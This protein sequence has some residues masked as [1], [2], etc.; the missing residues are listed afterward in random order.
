MELKFSQKFYSDFKTNRDVVFIYSETLDLLIVNVYNDARLTADQST[1]LCLTNF[2][3]KRLQLNRCLIIGDFNAHHT[4]WEPSR[5]S[6]K[7]GTELISLIDTLNLTVITP[8]NLPTHAY[9]CTGNSARTSTID[10][11]LCNVPNLI[12]NIA[13]YDPDIYTG[14]D[15]RPVS[16]DLC[17]MTTRRLVFTNNNHLNYK[18]ADWELVNR[19][20]ETAINPLMLQLPCCHPHNIETVTLCLTNAITKTCRDHIPCINP[21]RKRRHAIW[22]NENCRL[23]KKQKNAMDR[24]IDKLLDMTLISSRKSQLLAQRKRGFRQYARHLCVEKRA[25]LDTLVQ[26]SSRNDDWTIHEKIICFESKKDLPMLHT[27]QGTPAVNWEENFEVMRAKFFQGS[28]TT[29]TIDQTPPTSFSPFPPILASECSAAVAKM[30]NRTTG[31]DDK[32]N[33]LL[34]KKVWHTVEPIFIKLGNE[35][36]RHS[37]HPVSWKHA[38]TK[39]IP[40]TGRSDYLIA[41]SYRPIALLSILT[42]IFESIMSR[43]LSHIAEDRNLLPQ[44]QHGFRKNH[45]TTDGLTK[46][47]DYIHSGWKVKKVTSAL[48]LDLAG[49]YDNVC[50]T[51]LTLKLREMNFPCYVISWLNHFLTNRSTCIRNEEHFSDTWYLKKGLPQGS[52]I[53]SILFIL[54]TADLIFDLNA[55]IPTS[56]FADDI[57]LYVANASTDANVS[58]LKTAVTIANKWAINNKQTFDAGKTEL[59]HFDRRH[60]PNTQ[61]LTIHDHVITPTKKL[62]VLGVWFDPKLNWKTHVETTLRNTRSKWSRVLRCSRKITSLSYRTRRTIY[63]GVIEARIAYGYAVW[64]RISNSNFKPLDVFFNQVCRKICGALPKTKTA[65]CIIES[66]QIPLR[67]RLN[68][69]HERE[70]LKKKLNMMRF[71]KFTTIPPWKLPLQAFTFKVNSCPQTAIKAMQTTLL[72]LKPE[73]VSWPD[74]SVTNDG[75]AGAG[76]ILY[77]FQTDLPPIEHSLRVKD[78]STAE[79]CEWWATYM[80][81]MKA[82]ESASDWRLMCIFTDS[83]SIINSW[84][85]IQTGKN[86]HVETLLYDLNRYL[87]RENRRVQIQWIP[88]H[89]SILGNEIADALAKQATRLPKISIVPIINPVLALKKAQIEAQKQITNWWSNHRSKKSIFYDNKPD[90]KIPALHDNLIYQETKWITWIRTNAIPLNDHLS[91]MKLRNDNSCACSSESKFAVE[92]IDHFLF[93]C[94]RFNLLRQKWILPHGSTQQ[95]NTIT[96]IINSPTGRNDVLHFI[97]ASKRFER[98]S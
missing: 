93:H 28:S 87:I 33:I 14:L 27:A 81:I 83:Q 40:K 11:T 90:L 77:L 42:R 13:M 45:R 3:E 39:I 7:R 94:S 96:D 8:P 55:V 61:V 62:R 30:N 65:S 98:K 86:S 64:H 70:K 31:G 25:Y 49:A 20:L 18:N 1:I 88:G 34:I 26:S 15:H 9:A 67:L 53:S 10:L 56:S 95:P 72:E 69:I 79:E 47:V 75:K 82:R 29:P 66:G 12:K 52:P 2:F 71:K 80:S 32:L 73:V 24:R 57:I 43:R 22:W 63:Q 38:V 23:A 19:E 89:S 91:T 41:K 50:H 74:G 17:D 97:R 16:Y 59:M 76:F 4:D 78:E 5:S 6:D 37:H 84:K 58:Q 60:A 48:T 68:T 92:T 44:D 51:L 46:M 54:Y 36:L 85:K 35:I 21:R